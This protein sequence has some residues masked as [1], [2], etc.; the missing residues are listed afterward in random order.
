MLTRALA[1]LTLTMIGC[2]LVPPTPSPVGELDSGVPDITKPTPA[3]STVALEVITVADECQRALFVYQDKAEKTENARLGMQISGGVISIG[4][5][6]SGSVIAGAS[7]N[8]KSIGPTVAIVA[9][10]SFA[11]VGA[12]IALIGSVLSKDHESQYLARRRMWDRGKKLR[13]TS[14]QEAIEYFNI[15]TETDIPVG[16]QPQPEP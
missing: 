14:T 15:C 16:A 5:A 9:T 11:A 1:T 7:A 3:W 6:L 2:S 4:G 8:D 10:A 13:K 12:V